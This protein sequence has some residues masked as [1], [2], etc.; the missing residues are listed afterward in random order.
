M[1]NRL[2]F[3][4]IVS[5]LLSVSA[6]T[7]SFAQ[8]ISL[9]ING[10]SIES[11]V[12]PKIIEGRTMVPVR[13]I[14]EGIGAEVS[15]DAPSKTITGKKG[16]VTVEMK[17]GEKTM[18]VNGKN[19][20]MDAAAA[21]I[22]DRTYAPAR[23]VAETFGFDVSWN[24]D[25]KEVAINS[26]IAA[27]TEITTEVT[28]QKATAETTTKAI[29]TTEASTE[30]T[31]L[32]AA[33][34]LNSSPVHGVGAPTYKLIKNDILNAF[35]V[36]YV[37]NANNNNRFQRN[38]YNKL[39]T[40]WDSTAQTP[41]EK[42]FVIYAKQVYQNMITTCKKIDQRKAKYPANA[43]IAT[44]CTDRKDKLEVMLKDFLASKDIDT[45]KANAE[46]IKTFAANTVAS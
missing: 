13:T 4:L 7:A 32:S 43:N 34:I 31:T 35:N 24:A 10:K 30:T 9:K 2:I 1:K 46:K 25:L 22:D 44:Y 37:G 20:E 17:I 39:M 12:E 18:S 3:T 23:Y 27:T 33:E 41:E 15:W 42:T 8:G 29:V 6:L 19:I 45:A 26:K 14:F 38:T 40:V 36:Y 28:T 16:P 21:I 5:S 11:D